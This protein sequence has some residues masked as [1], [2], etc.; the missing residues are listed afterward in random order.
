MTD[1]V[2]GQDVFGLVRAAIHGERMK[3][4]REVE[5]LT[6]TVKYNARHIHAY[7]RPGSLQPVG[8]PAHHHWVVTGD[9]VALQV[10]HAQLAAVNQ[11]WL[12]VQCAVNG[13]IGAISDEGASP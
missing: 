1:Q 4:L 3:A 11:V 6:D 2:T 13:P 12:A 9:Q 7:D 10:A 8:I 5:R